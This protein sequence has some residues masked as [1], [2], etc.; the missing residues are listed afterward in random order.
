V[1][2][3]TKQQTTLS[4]VADGRVASVLYEEAIKTRLVRARPLRQTAVRMAE[5]LTSTLRQREKEDVRSVP[6]SRSEGT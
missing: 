4:G 5:E 1:R 2:C 3:P 6:F